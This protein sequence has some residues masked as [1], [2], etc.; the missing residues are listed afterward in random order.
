MYCDSR[1]QLD[2]QINGTEYSPEKDT[3][4]QKNLADYQAVIS[5]QQRNE[6]ISKKQHWDN[7]LT[8]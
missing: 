5:N 2:L 1:S 3:R 7:W 6:N 4:K 8:V